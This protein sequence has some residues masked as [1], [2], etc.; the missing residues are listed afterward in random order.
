MKQPA[1]GFLLEKWTHISWKISE[2]HNIL[3]HN[4][5]RSEKAKSTSVE[6][7]E[8]IEC[9]KKQIIEKCE[10]YWIVID[11][12]INIKK[13][14]LIWSVSSIQ[15]RFFLKWGLLK[16]WDLVI[17][18]FINW[19]RSNCLGVIVK[20]LSSQ[21]LQRYISDYLKKIQDIF[22]GLLK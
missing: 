1:T 19:V 8:A 13:I 2:Q 4:W 22:S 5:F 18:T 17:I 12:N 6:S 14:Y 20:R 16:A 7:C 21:S 11:F 10:L 3:L 9:I 15:M